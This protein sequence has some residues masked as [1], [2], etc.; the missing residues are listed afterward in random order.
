MRSRSVLMLASVAMILVATGIENAFAAN[1]YSG[2]DASTMHYSGYRYLTWDSSATGSPTVSRGTSVQWAN[3]LTIS[4]PTRSYQPYIKYNDPA[5]GETT[6]TYPYWLSDGSSWT[7]SS[8]P[9][10]LGG[11]TQTSSG[12]YTSIT[13]W[14][15]YDP[16]GAASGVSNPNNQHPWTVS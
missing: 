4:D 11:D 7:I 13:H 5:R 16:G 10:A 3:S 14:Y 12:S 6:V 15:K 1:L 9:P 8:N 2:T